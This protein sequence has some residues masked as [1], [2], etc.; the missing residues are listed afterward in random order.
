MA[1]QI[2]TGSLHQLIAVWP[3]QGQAAEMVCNLKY[4][5]L[6]AAVSPLAEAMA[7]RSPDIDFVCWVPASPSRRRKRG[8]DQGELLARAVARRKRVRVKRLLK[9]TD[10]L[11]QTSRDLTGREQGP[12]FS[13]LGAR[14]PL[15][16]V[17]LLVDDVAT[18]GTTLNNAAC[19]L[20]QRGAGRVYGLVATVAQ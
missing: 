5:R 1:K 13:T 15:G 3:H 9:R 17:V 16:A 2:T 7:Q 14:L 4:G 20:R 10:D 12:Q 8:F 18:T 6:T 19:L 11:P